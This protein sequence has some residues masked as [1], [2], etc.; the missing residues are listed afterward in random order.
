MNIVA[1]C[2][3]CGDEFITDATWK[4]RCLVCFKKYQDSGRDASRSPRCSSKTVFKI[5]KYTGYTFEEVRATD[6]SYGDWAMLHAG[7]TGQ[8]AAFVAWLKGA[9]SPFKKIKLVPQE[10]GNEN[11]R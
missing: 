4:Q 8:I 3:D 10:D 1:S 9:A 7:R 2:R 11:D 6:P 5:G